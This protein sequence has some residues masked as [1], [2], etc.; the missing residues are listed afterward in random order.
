MYFTTHLMAGAA[1]GGALARVGLPPAWA[2]LAGVTSHA[3]L[4]MIPHH[5]YHQAR[6]ALLDIL[7]GTALAW[8]VFPGPAVVARLWG[9]C[10]GVLPDLE[11]AVNHVRTSLGR[12]AGQNS[13]PTHS[14]ILSHRG[15]VFPGGALVQA[16]I[17]LLGLLLLVG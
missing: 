13:F 7:A 12:P 17:V 8:L 15:W 9:A 3:A 5:D 4:D 16:G 14:G 10:G 1:V 11:V 6:W 2:F